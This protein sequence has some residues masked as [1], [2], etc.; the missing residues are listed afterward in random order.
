LIDAIH[1]RNIFKPYTPL[2]HEVDDAEGEFENANDEAK[3]MRDIDESVHYV[4]WRRDE[5]QTV[6]LRTTEAEHPPS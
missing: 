6:D 4:R 1:K 5:A 3:K 2:Y